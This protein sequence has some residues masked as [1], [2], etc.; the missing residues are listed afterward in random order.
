MSTVHASR[1]GLKPA[2][3][4]LRSEVAIVCGLAKATLGVDWSD[5]MDDYRAIRARIAE[6]VPG[7]EDF[8]H[9][10]REGFTLAQGPRDSRIFPTP[11]GKAHFTS[12]PLEVMAVPEG[13]L[14]LQTI[15]SHDQ[16]NTTIY[17]LDDR[18]RGVKGGRK[19]VFVNP[20]DL[21]A[22][23]LTDGETVDIVS[24]WADG[25]RRAEGFRIIAY[26]TAKGCA[27]A[28]FPEANILVPLDSTADGSNTPTSKQVIVR[29]VR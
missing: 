21:T 1:G 5:Y 20:A 28:Y 11:D 19:V 14:I 24:E 26:P 12:T 8:E 3:P 15:R 2:S 6:T 16:Y 7:F 27:A 4:H 18:Y 29:F 10:V 22:L 25:E 23:G 17:G 9:R 13:R